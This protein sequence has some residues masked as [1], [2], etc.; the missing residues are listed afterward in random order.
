M[1]LEDFD[2][3]KYEP[4]Q[5][6]HIT[7]H[8]EGSDTAGSHFSKAAFPTAKELVDY[9]YEHIQDYLGQKL[10]REVDAGRTIGYDGLISLENLPQEAR[11][12]QEP[13]G[14]DGYSTNVVRGVQ[15]NP[16]SKIVIVA[17]PLREEGKHGLY[18]IYPGTN[19][20]PFPATKEKLI[21]M[22]YSGEELDTQVKINQTYKE[23]WDNHGFIVD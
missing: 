14:R 5:M 17:G 15:K 6:E 23:F 7:R 11:V 12:S 21:E 9:A 2:F 16:T 1:A 18:T 3:V 22:G 8:L 13:R 4:K 19:A 10:V 20:P